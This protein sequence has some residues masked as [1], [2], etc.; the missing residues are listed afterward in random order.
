MTASL[1]PTITRSDSPSSSPS[2]SPS[3]R[4]SSTP[5]QRPSITDSTSPSSSPSTLPSRWPSSTPSV[6]T[7]R[8]TPIRFVPIATNAPVTRAPVTPSPT[9]SLFPPISTPRPTIATP[10]PTTNAP[11]SPRP[12]MPLFVPV[13]TTAPQTPRPTFS[14][15][16][17]ITTAVPETPRPTIIVTP[18][19]TMQVTPRPTISLFQPIETGVP[20]GLATSA[21]VVPNTPEPTIVLVPNTAQ[22][23]ELTPQPTIVDTTVNPMT[24]RPTMPTN[25]ITPRPTL[26]LFQP[27]VTAVP[28]VLETSEPVRPSDEPMSPQP[29]ASSLQ[30]VESTELT[31]SPV[32][33]PTG[34]VPTDPPTPAPTVFQTLSENPPATDMTTSPS[35]SLATTLPPT[36]SSNGTSSP[37]D[38]PFNVQTIPPTRAQT[39][40]FPVEPVEFV[41]IPN[42]T[43]GRGRC[44][45]AGSTGLPCAP[46]DLESLCNKYDRSEGRMSRCLSACLPSFCCVHNTDATKN[47][48]APSCR[49]DENCPQYNSCY[50]AW[51]K[52][53]DLVGPSTTLHLDQTDDF[54]DIAIPQEVTEDTGFFRQVLFHHFDDVDDVID[55]IKQA[56]SVE[57]VFTLHRLWGKSILSDRSQPLSSTTV[58]S[59]TDSSLRRNEQKRKREREK[60]LGK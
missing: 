60:R 43:N 45:D 29:I 18:E 19:P 36:S 28:V 33:L 49:T 4:P 47:S 5:S 6:A 50:I 52:L 37:S 21:P 11:V 14:L 23:A 32:L 53:S 54:F 3:R 24:P 42:Y 46:N 12:T 7:P 59:R 48:L 10:V 8:P 58:T 57:D 16:Q 9:F 2:A 39:G 41:D 34:S 20:V 15:F 22:P 55:S 51:W 30:P 31:E 38:P 35:T 17:P 25:S 13:A 27:I 40:A 26:H 44:P 56:R 1:L